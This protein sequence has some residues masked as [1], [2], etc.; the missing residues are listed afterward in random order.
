[1]RHT[2]GLVFAQALILASGLSSGAFAEDTGGQPVESGVK[3][4]AGKTAEQTAGSNAPSSAMDEIVVMAQRTPKSVARRAELEAPNLINIQTYQEIRKLPDITAAEAVRRIPGI[5][6]ETDEGEGRYVNCR[7][8]DADL[9]STT[10]GGLRLPPTNNAS[11]FGGYRAV[12]LDSI[13]IGVVGAITVTK[14]NLPEQDAEALG[15]TI[16]ITPR[17]APPGNEPFLQGNIGTGYE[18]NRSTGVADLAVTTGGHFGPF[19]IVLS[20]TYNEDRRGID[21][22]EPAYFNDSKHPYTAINNIQQRDY[23][24]HRWRHGASIDLGYQPDEDDNW[25]VRAFDF[26]YTERYL[27]QF[28]NLTPDGNTK[29]LPNGSIQDTLTGGSAIQSALRDEK[30]TSND[31][32]YVAGGKNVFDGIILDYRAAYTKGTYVKPYDY[33]SAFSFAPP[34]TITYNNSGPG[35]VPVYKITG[36]PGYLNPSNYTLSSFN[37]SVANNFDKEY[38]FASNLEVPLSLTGADS[39]SVKFGVSARL[40]HKRITSQP[41]SYGT[42]PGLSL[43]D[44]TPGG[45][46]TYYGGVYQNGVDISPGYLQGLLGPGTAAAADVISAQQQYLDV[47]EDVYAAYAQYQLTFGPFGLIGGVRVEQTRDHAHAFATSVIDKA[48]DITVTPVTASNHYT[49][50]FPSLQGKFEIEPNLILRATWSSTLARPGFNQSNAALN[51]DLGAGIVTEG[52]PKLRP[53]TADSFDITLEKYLEDAG[54][55]SVGFFDKE[56]SDYIVASELTSRT[57]P[58]VNLFPGNTLPLHIFTYSN[59]P[60]SYARGIEFNWEE[61]L[62]DLPGILDGLGMAL[63]YTY[64]DSSF[65]IRPGQTSSLPST[66]QHTWNAALFYERDG[67]TL[68]MAAYSV[69]ADLFAIGTDKTSDVYNGERISLDF[70]SS[71]AIDDTWSVYFNAKN[72]L[73]TPHVFYQGTS[74]RPIQREFYG[75]TYL[76][77]VRFD[78]EGLGSEEAETAAYTPPPVAAP[79]LAAPRSYLVFFDF[80]KSDL[81]PQAVSIVNQAAANAGPAHVTQLT[82][83]GHTDTVG[84]DA[85]N[86]RLS[87]RRAESVAAQLEKDGIRASEIDIVAK[88]KRDLLVPTAD[89]VREPQNRRVQI[90]Y[91]GGAAS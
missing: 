9:N 29:P 24:L 49:N 41:L 16:E 32:V 5:S 58:N 79:A 70:G 71:Y 83:T 13:P 19:S 82:V 25:Y 30:E 3:V 67:L 43:A 4:A 48:G 89:G 27:R 47:H 28:L 31:R 87:R 81:T 33:N 72:L 54:I 84:S 91:S 78:F 11:P 68:R 45:Q 15:C 59:T 64:V 73:D 39:E 90:V 88:G 57:I 55:L 60:S 69:S 74:N 38:S 1:M 37:N 6:L 65:T 86:M 53:A 50:V 10:F 8:L 22:V 17:T 61:K 7:G 77:G 23:E 26:G 56:F 51:I 36:A 40:R 80:N 21:D 46:E 42:L 20:G 75:Q 62:P 14:S 35:N 12:T 44:V 18:P 76:I 2:L 34:A 85:Y 66:S 63:N 52:N